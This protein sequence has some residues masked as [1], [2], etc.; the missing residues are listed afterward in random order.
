MNDIPTNFGSGALL[1]SGIAAALEQ[2]K[3]EDRKAIES[4]RCK[5]C[6]LI[7]S[8]QQ[9]DT[10][11]CDEAIQKAGEAQTELELVASE[12]S[13][14][15]SN[16]IAEHK[17]ARRYLALFIQQHGLTRKAQPPKVGENLAQLAL[18]TS[19]EACGT[20]L[21]LTAG[22]AMPSFAEA[23]GL[24]LTASGTVILISAGSGHIAGRH[25]WYGVQGGLT[26]SVTLVKRWSARIAAPILA[27]GL[28]MLI[29]AMAIVRGT[30]ELSNI[31]FSPN[32]LHAAATDIQA[33]LLFA[34]GCATSAF[35][36]WKGLSAF[37]DPYPGYLHVA[38]AA[39]VITEDARNTYDVAIDDIAVCVEDGREE[40]ANA[41]S[42]LEEARNRRV[43]ALAQAKCVRELSLSEIEHSAA[44]FYA[45]RAKL[46]QNYRAVT[47]HDPEGAHIDWHDRRVL[48]GA[49]P[50]IKV[51]AELSL[52]SAS[53]RLNAASA[54]LDSAAEKAATQVQDAYRNFVAQ[55]GG[56][57][58]GT[59]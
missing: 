33:I 53:E 38:R 14:E 6:D 18:L 45:Y 55:T 26:D 21:F 27:A 9:E 15:L 7:A 22:G 31:T 19:I 8:I 5:L 13:A 41:R 1:D 49:M 56:C 3:A 20:G 42:A 40:I 28:G 34:F 50:D 12:A 54:A 35:A 29:T 57:R 59:A 48:S 10:T 46:I 58:N 44:R 2:R 4:M 36:W 43:D 11:A 23:G 52:T 30:G 39:D 47:G 17:D 25:I 32:Q 37:S 51:D 16:A 24:A